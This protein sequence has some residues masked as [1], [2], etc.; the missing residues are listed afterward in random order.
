[1]VAV[2]VESTASLT[3]NNLDITGSATTGTGSCSTGIVLSGAAKLVAM[4]LAASRLGTALD[5]RD[6]SAT[7]IANATVSGNA[8]CAGLSLMSVL[9]TASFSLSDSVLDGRANGVA[10]VAQSASFHAT[11][12]NTV[13]GNM[14]GDGLVGF[15]SLK[16]S[17]QMTGGELSNNGASGAELGKGAWLFECSHSTEQAL[18]ILFAGCECGNEE[19]H[20]CW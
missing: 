1:M 15:P 12:S 2:E 17:F 4:T 8:T 6:Q 16:G 19:L 9:S 20:S 14:K 3:V 7:T 10:I 18:R 11:I 13:I 5:A